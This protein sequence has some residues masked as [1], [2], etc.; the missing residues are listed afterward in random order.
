MSE[1][2]SYIQKGHHTLT[3]YLY[4]G[5][6]LL[7]FVQNVF[8]AEVTHNP[9]PDASGEFHSEVRIGDSMLLIGNGYFADS[10]M[11]AATWIYVKD[12]D[13]TYKHALSAGAKGIREPAD[14]TWGDRVAGVKDTFG[15][16]WWIATHTAKN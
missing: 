15:N 11:A 8:G 9:E 1:D 4:G 7:E 13:A 3:S 5:P 2:R 12:V 16:T 14:Q 10:S 6:K